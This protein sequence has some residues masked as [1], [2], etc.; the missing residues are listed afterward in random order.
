MMEKKA[1]MPPV[2]AVVERLEKVGSTNDELKRR[3]WEG[4]PHGLV[5]TAAEQTAGRGRMGRSF[6]SPKGKG[7]YFSVLLRPECPPAEAVD[8]TAWIAVAVCRAIEGCTGL[9]PEIKWTND[10]LL[11]GKKLCGILTEMQ[12]SGEGLD[13]VVAGIGINL[14]HEAGDLSEDVAAI[15]TSLGGHLSVPPTA[16]EM[17]RALIGA[18]NDMAA[19]FPHEKENWLAEYRRRCVTLGKEVEVRRGDQVRYGRALEL[20]G[21]FRLIVE[22]EDGRTEA[23]ESGEVSVKG[24]Y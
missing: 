14:N 3:A 21:A 7:L 13:W 16:E 24:L 22:F 8:L 2:G 18:L 6:Q 23:L 12:T 17:T 9:C 19:E 4:A 10:I 20:D 1:V 11:G 15:A 5:L